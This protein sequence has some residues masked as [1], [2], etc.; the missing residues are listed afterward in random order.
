M[1]TIYRG[2]VNDHF[3][4]HYYKQAKDFFE[5][6][7]NGGIEVGNTISVYDL[8]KDIRKDFARL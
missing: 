5:G 8:S 4:Y 1:V 6:I 2:F 3:Y 7:K